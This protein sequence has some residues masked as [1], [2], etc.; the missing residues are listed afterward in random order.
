MVEVFAEGP[1]ANGRLQVAV[2]RGDH[3]H[4]RLEGF[5][6]AHAVVGAATQDAQKARL[7]FHRHVADFIEKERPARGLSETTRTRS[8]RPR[9]GAFFMPEEFALQK[10]PR[11]RRHVEG[12][13]GRATSGTVLPEGACHHFL[14]RPGFPRKEH[15]DGALRKPSDRTEHFLHGGRTTDEA[16]LGEGRVLGCVRPG[17]S[18]GARPTRSNRSARSGLPGRKHRLGCGFERAF[19]ARV[20]GRGTLD[21][22]QHLLDVKGLRKVLEGTAPVRGNGALQIGEGRHDEYGHLREGRI[23]ALH[24]FHPRKAGH[25]DVGEDDGGLFGLAELH[26]F[27]LLEHR[28]AVLERTGSMPRALKR[29]G[30]HPADRPI[31]VD[32][33]DGSLR[34]GRF[35]ARCVTKI[36]RRFGTGFVRQF[37]SPWSVS[38]P[39]GGQALVFRERAGSNGNNTRNTVRPGRLSTSTDPPASST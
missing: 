35:T 32:H 1:F 19:A 12:A 3:A 38:V 30:E 18:G 17:T 20:L 29:A 37:R 31:V 21:Q 6:T 11:S 9:K 34:C 23:E 27:E 15:G 22:L 7:K 14:A 5:A 24:Q 25:A 33:P 28:G 4:V 13:V 39:S 10:L 26:R 36:G 2:R 8:A 16:V